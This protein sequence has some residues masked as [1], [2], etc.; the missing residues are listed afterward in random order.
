MF[1]EEILFKSRCAGVTLV[2]LTLLVEGRRG[3][4][5]RVHRGDKRSIWAHENSQD[6]VGERSMTPRQLDHDR[7]TAAT[8]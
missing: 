7:W 2:N 8:T 1:A 5:P 3:R 4:T 6:E